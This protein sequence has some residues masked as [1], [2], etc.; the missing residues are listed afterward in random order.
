MEEKESEKT[1][2]KE[3]TLR[4]GDGKETE[5]EEVK[6]VAGIGGGRKGGGEGEEQGRGEERGGEEKV[7]E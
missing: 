2:E 1:F 4:G 7:M 5:A 6:K 3:T